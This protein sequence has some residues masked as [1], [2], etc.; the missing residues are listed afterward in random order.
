MHGASLSHI[1]MIYI[2]IYRDICLTSCSEHELSNT[3]NGANDPETETRARVTAGT[4]Y[5]ECGRQPGAND[6]EIGNKCKGHS[7]NITR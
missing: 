6:P 7:R 1:Y 5:A 2:Y 4:S 3:E